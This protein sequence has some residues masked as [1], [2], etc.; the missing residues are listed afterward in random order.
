MPNINVS[1]RDQLLSRSGLPATSCDFLKAA[2][3]PF[4]D[5]K[6]R[7]HGLPDANNESTVS[8]LITHSFTVSAPAGTAANWNACVF[9]TPND[10]LCSLYP[11]RGAFGQY[12]A[13]SG[14]TGG[15]PE[16]AAVQGIG[17]QDAA[18]TP[19]VTFGATN[20]WTWNIENDIFFPYGAG[21]YV[22]PTEAVSDSVLEQAT[23]YGDYAG[24][25]SAVR[26][27]VYASGFEITN[28]TSQLNKQGTLTSVRVPAGLSRHD[29]VFGCR[30][31]GSIPLLKNATTGPGFFSAPR[32]T[33]QIFQSPPPTLAMAMTAGATQRAAAQGDYSLST[34]DQLENRICQSQLGPIAMDGM[35]FNRAATATYSSATATA[36][37]NMA[38]TEVPG[39]DPNVSALTQNA[40]QHHLSPR[41]INCVYLTGLSKETTFTVTCKYVIEIAPRTTDADFATLVPLKQPAP[42]MDLYALQLYQRAIESIPNSVPVGMNPTGEW[43]GQIFGA[44]SRA[45]PAISGMASEVLGPEAA[46]LGPAGNLAGAGLAAISRKLAP[47]QSAVAIVRTVPKK[48]KKIR[49]ASS[50]VSRASSRGRRVTISGSNGVKNRSR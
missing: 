28:T 13:I 38:F 7:P 9:T 37:A 29:N 23:G 32:S 48:K 36:W 34:Y 24:L 21:T 8:E 31:N 3:D 26:Y 44:L 6:L 22:P 16:I 10:A 47:N 4:H 19:N 49:R 11:V 39:T 27:R 1:R 12:A 25:T 17:Y 43:W 42:K 46:F 50:A 14:Y 18:T 20:V 40:I 5:I 2:L 41:D 45:I 33:Y 30:S 35:L 15:N